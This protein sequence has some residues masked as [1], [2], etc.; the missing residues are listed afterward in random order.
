MCDVDYS[1]SCCRVQNICQKQGEMEKNK[2]GG[3][4]A[5]VT[6][7]FFERLE[8]LRN[9]PSLFLLSLSANFSLSHFQWQPKKQSRC[10][11]F[12]LS[13]FS[14]RLHSALP[15]A[16]PHHSSL[17]KMSSQRFYTGDEQGLIKGTFPFHNVKFTAILHLSSVLSLLV[18]ST[19]YPSNRTTLSTYP[20]P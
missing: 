20:P 18:H 2:E 16:S 10:F 14:A 1:P 12:L 4:Y 6:V 8:P 19:N 15:F 9:E 5:S 11:L 17:K 3:K 13:F 7:D